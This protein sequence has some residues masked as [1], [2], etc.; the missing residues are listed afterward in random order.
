M[1][2]TIEGLFKFRGG[3]HRNGIGMFLR[4]HRKRVLVAD[5]RLVLAELPPNRAIPSVQNKGL[6]K[7]DPL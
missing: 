5:P 7:G 3:V 1:A 2:T 4:N 6:Q